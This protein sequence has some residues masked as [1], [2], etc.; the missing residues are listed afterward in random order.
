[1]D[2]AKNIKSEIC[3]LSLAKNNPIDK[4]L[5]LCYNHYLG[6]Y[7]HNNIK[8]RRVYMSKK[9]IALI[10]VALLSACASDAEVVTKPT[11]PLDLKPAVEPMAQPYI[12]TI[13]SNTIGVVYEYDNMSLQEIADKATMYC[14]GEG[15]KTFIK[16]T[17]VLKNGHQTASFVCE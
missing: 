17:S 8:L 2:G 9:I 15:K 13:I 14:A 10:A 16:F 3:F 11:E 4:I 12:Q 1:M 6:N 5:Y 7:E